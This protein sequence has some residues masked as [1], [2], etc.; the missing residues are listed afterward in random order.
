MNTD[1]DPEL[2]L[3]LQNLPGDSHNPEKDSKG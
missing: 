1:K 2:L 3:T